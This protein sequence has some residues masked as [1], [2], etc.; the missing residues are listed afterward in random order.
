MLIKELI[1]IPSQTG[2]E[3]QINTFILGWLKD[4][5]IRA[6]RQDENII[7]K[8]PGKNR[9][10]A[11]VLNGH[12]DTVV[13]GNPDEWK[14][15]PFNPVL[16][17]GLIYGLGAS[18]MKAGVAALMDIAQFYSKNMPP[19]DLWFTF[20]VGEE[21][22]GRGT[23][24]FIKWFTL[25]HHHENYEM[26]EAIIA[27]PTNN[28]F[29]GV[30]HRGNAFVQLTLMGDAGHASLAD[31]IKSKVVNELADICEQVQILE[32]KLQN[33][34]RHDYLGLPTVGIT[35]IQAGELKTPN[36]LPSTGKVVLDIR[37]TP[38]FH[39]HLNTELREFTQSLP[40]DTYFELIGVSPAGWCP[41]HSILRSI[42]SKHYPQLRHDIMNGSA[43][44]CFFSEKGIPCIII[45]P[46]QRDKMHG[47]NE[48]IKLSSIDEYT[49]LVKNI[50][51]EYGSV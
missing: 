40:Y 21:V 28:E 20:V 49:D 2:N 47:L 38:L 37:T 12:V 44:Q 30:G 39:S 48:S 3:S 4:K 23:Q 32:K 34:Y 29:V 27:E 45:G 18:D 15:G 42:L 5:K 8:I 6:F 7:A 26:I 31:T 13:E 14:Y 11:L 33:E 35:G 1:K 36:R 50:I 16:R 43:D 17:E 10:R 41:E 51:K 46:G 19:C 22:D 24:S 9:T 25:E